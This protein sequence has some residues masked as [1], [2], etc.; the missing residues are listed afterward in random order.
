MIGEGA[1]WQDAMDF[2]KQHQ[3]ENLQ[4]IP[5]QPEEKLPFTMPLADIALVALDAGAEG[6]MIPSKMFYYMSAG[7]AVVGI[8]SGRNDVSVI[9]NEAACGVTVEPQQPAE[10]ARVIKALASD[11]ARLES[12]KKKARDAALASYSR[13]ACMRDLAASV[14][15]VLKS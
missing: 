11:A 15:K 1:K 7:A 2:Q 5:F 8:C 13:K 9:V 6:L 14:I 3:L 10:L 4:V 12:Y